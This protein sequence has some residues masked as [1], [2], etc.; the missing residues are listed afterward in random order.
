MLTVRLGAQ[1]HTHVCMY[2]YIYM[3]MPDGRFGDHVFS[4]NVAVRG[5]PKSRSGPMRV[6]HCKNRSEE[7]CGNRKKAKNHKLPTPWAKSSVLWKHTPEF[8]DGTAERDSSL[9]GCCPYKN[10][11]F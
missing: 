7:K 10:S 5:P 8:L 9:M 4:K 11:V 3:H 2:V 1:T 6:S